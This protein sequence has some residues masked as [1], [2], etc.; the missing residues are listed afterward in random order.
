MA[1]VKRTIKNNNIYYLRGI[2]KAP[3]VI[4]KW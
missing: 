3:Y 2:F 4:G 1:N